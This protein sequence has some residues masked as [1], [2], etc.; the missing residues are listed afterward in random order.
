MGKCMGYEAVWKIL[1]EIVIELRKKGLAT[2][3]R[4]M[5]DLKSAKVYIKIMDA[6][7]KDRGETAPRIEQYLG[8][9]EAYLITEAQ[10]TFAPKKIDEWLRR[11][12]EASYGTC[13]TCIEPKETKKKE[14][15]K[16]ITGVPRD[17]KWIRVK[18]LAILSVEKLR[19]IAKKQRLSSR[20]QKDGRLLVFG[21]AEDIRDFVKKMTE[22]NTCYSLSLSH[23][24]YME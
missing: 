3:Q 5:N 15:A 4:V 21:K 16:F 24:N 23:K 1:E 11:L 20:L 10:K 2:P 19:E 22:Q 12:E 7:E 17:Q 14:E 8:S 13:Q 9:V 6:S 18:P